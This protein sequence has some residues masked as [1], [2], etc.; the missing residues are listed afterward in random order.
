MIVTEHEVTIRV[1]RKECDVQIVSQCGMYSLSVL[2]L[3]IKKKVEGHYN[4]YS[5]IKLYKIDAN[6]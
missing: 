5:K 4:Y 6:L 2:N 1:I 3:N